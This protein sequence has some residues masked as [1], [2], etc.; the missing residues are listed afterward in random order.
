MSSVSDKTVQVGWYRLCRR[1]PDMARTHARQRAARRAVLAGL[2]VAAAVAAWMFSPAPRR[3]A[4]IPPPGVPP[5]R[6]KMLVAAPLGAIER[7]TDATAG[8]EGR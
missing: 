3:S 8:V 6:K 5:L 4:T 1:L 7:A 2:G